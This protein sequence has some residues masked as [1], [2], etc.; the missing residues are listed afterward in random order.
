VN[1]KV[2]RRELFL[3]KLRIARIGPEGL[4][5]KL[6]AGEPVFIIDLRNSLDV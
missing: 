3:R 5:T 2:T 6:T 4:E 1:V